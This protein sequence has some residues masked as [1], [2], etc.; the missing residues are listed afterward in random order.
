MEN[1]L[2]AIIL[3][4]LLAKTANNS[5]INNNVET[6]LFKR[7]EILNK[8]PLDWKISNTK[9]EILMVSTCPFSNKVFK[10]EGYRD[11]LEYILKLFLNGQEIHKDS[12]YI[13]FKNTRD[14]IDLLNEFNEQYEKSKTDILSLA[15]SLR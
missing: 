12:K 14:K 11:K 8:Y 2:N 15:E 13:E 4:K 9:E 3:D 6:F 7:K 5:T 10:I 1:A